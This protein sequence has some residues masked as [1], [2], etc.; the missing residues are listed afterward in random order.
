MRFFSYVQWLA[1]SQWKAVKAHA[2]SKGV[3]LMG[4]IP[5]GVSYHSADVWAHPQFFKT[6]WCGGTPPDKVFK[7]D[8]FVQKWGQNWGIPLYDWDAMR[9]GDFLWWRRR[10]RGVR[11]FF[12]LFR[13]DHVLG[14]YRI[15]GFPWKPEENETYLPLTE[16]EA[17]A[18][19]GGMLPGFHPRP[20]DTPENKA[21]N[22]AEG[23]EILR[24][25][26]EEAGQGR[27][28]G[29]DL[30]ELP[31]YIRPSLTSLGIAGYRVPQWEKLRNGELIPGRKYQRLSLTTYATHDHPPIRAMWEELAKAAKKDAQSQRELQAL[32]RYI[33][34]G[35]SEPAARFTSTV[36]KAL[37][38]ELFQSNSWIAAVMITDVFARAERF[39]YPGVAGDAN[40]TQRMHAPLAE[41]HGHLGADRIR[42]IL[43][44]T[45]RTASLPEARKVERRQRRVRMG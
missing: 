31:D 14:F 27:V 26:L 1:F 41:L 5:F 9:T 20:D 16:K 32:S 39:N 19:T 22:R 33:G 4:D 35:K 11:E 6:G 18:R 2:G 30:G 44:T 36:H 45:G 38:K 24:V 29:E 25:I 17:C 34:C 12:N 8:P 21:L 40:W 10:V 28:V 3:A 7:H 37:L 13:I 42:K 43:K 15:Y 23:E